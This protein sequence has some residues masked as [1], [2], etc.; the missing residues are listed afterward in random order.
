MFTL[1]RWVLSGTANRVPG[2]VGS[3]GGKASRSAGRRNFR[4]LAERLEDRTCP[5]VSTVSPLTR[6]AVDDNTLSDIID[7]LSDTQPDD[8]QPQRFNPAQK[9]E[10]ANV[11]AN[12]HQESV[13]LG[14][15]AAHY[16]E[17]AARFGFVAGFTLPFAGTGVGAFAS[18]AATGAAA[19]YQWR[20]AEYAVESA[21]AER[22]SEE[23]RALA[24]DPPDPHFTSV[25]RPTPFVWVLTTSGGG[26]APP[27]IDAFNA[28]FLNESQAI[29]VAE[30]IV[31]SINRAS[32]AAAAGDAYW[33]GQQELAIAT[34]SAQLAALLGAQGALRAN[35]QA[36]LRAEGAADTVSLADAAAFT[37]GVA[38][39]GLPSLV[40][41]ILVAS[42]VDSATLARITHRTAKWNPQSIAGDVVAG[43]TDPALLDGLQG[44][45]QAL[46]LTAGSAP[47]HPKKLTLNRSLRLRLG[48]ARFDRATR[49]FRQ[50]VTVRNVSSQ[51]IQGPL[52]LV[53][54]HLSR[55]VRLL[56]AGGTT[57]FMAPTGSPFTDFDLGADGVL[58]PGESATLVLDFSSPT[59][60]GIRYTPRV[61][62]GIGLR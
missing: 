42:G 60:P 24:H 8:G 46:G 30:A 44:A 1:A 17:L 32:G 51:T 57:A 13:R 12:L 11:S 4:P 29:A 14:A 35:V 37:A 7:T 49:F 16:S 31:T 61:L 23:Y 34:Y 43:M 2:G 6:S 54:G 55:K 15:L 47:V 21:D 25:A 19:T 48:R 3:R 36:A 39:N 41:Q 52:S 50:R 10:F 53:L 18:G 33:K 56:Q 38:R 58:R 26:K 28:L 40:R 59:A 20:A 22:E 27:T 5:S 9:L 62:A 45:A